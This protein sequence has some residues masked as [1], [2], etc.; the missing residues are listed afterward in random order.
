M[1]VRVKRTAHE[2]LSD[3]VLEHTGAND[4]DRI[5]EC[6][7]CGNWVEEENGTYAEA[8]NMCTHCW[9]MYQGG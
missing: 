6:K 3:E 9:R 5:F 8:N 7:E 1:S 4:S 2:R